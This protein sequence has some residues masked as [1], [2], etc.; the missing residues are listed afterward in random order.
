MR[1]DR[2]FRQPKNRPHRELKGWPHRQLKGGIHK[3]LKGGIHRQLKGRSSRQPPIVFYKS[4]WGEL[5]KY[6]AGEMLLQVGEEEDLN[7]KCKSGRYPS[8]HADW[9][10]GT[11]VNV[12]HTGSTLCSIYMAIYDWVAVLAVNLKVTSEAWLFIDGFID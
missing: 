9:R 8:G 6:Q 4:N 10:F 12:S 3:Q 7:K 2:S 11:C 5:I 1:K